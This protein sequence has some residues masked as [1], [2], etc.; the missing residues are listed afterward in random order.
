MEAK[1]EEKKV[2]RLLFL[3]TPHNAECF[4]IVIAKFIVSNPSPFQSMKQLTKAIVLTQH[5]CSIAF[6]T[7]QNIEQLIHYKTFSHDFSQC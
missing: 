6:F 5:N 2:S 3:A 7:L 1:K 4:R